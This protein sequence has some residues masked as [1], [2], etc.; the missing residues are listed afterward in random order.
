MNVE[1]LSVEEK[2][3][4]LQLLQLRDKRQRENMLMAYKPY[5]KQ[6][7]FHEAG[8]K[9][10]E[11][12]FM[13]GNQLGKTL[14]GS[15]ET[16]MHLT[17]RYPEWWTGLRFRRPI[18][19]ICGSETAELT[20]KGV[21][22][23]LLGPPEQREMW[24]TGA[25]PMDCVMRT[26]MLQGVPDAVA[27]ITVANEYGGESV[28]QFSS[29]AQGRAKWQA[30]TLDWVWFD[31]EPPEDIYS[32]GLTRTQAV[33]GKVIVTFTPLLG[34]SAVVKRFLRDKP[35]GTNVTRM[36]IDDAEHYTQEQR[37]AAVAKM[38]PHERDARARGIP[39]MGSGLVFPVAESTIQVEPFEIPQH[40]SRIN[41]WDF[42]WGHRAAWVALAHDRDTDTA[43]V[44]D[45]WSAKET[46]VM[47]QAGMVM[48]K[49][50]HVIPHAWPHDG[51]QHDK[52]SGEQLKEQYKKFGINM[53][54]ERAQF[55]PG[56]DGKPGGNSVEAGVAMM[57]TRFQSRQLR[58]F[59][60]LGDWFDEFRMYHRKDGIVVKMDDDLMSA[61]R[62]ALMDLRKAKTLQELEP[63]RRPFSPPQV[64][65]EKFQPFDEAV[66]Y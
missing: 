48:A 29:Y 41:A 64:L 50:S 12:L 55:A 25:I 60:H 2:L 35:P 61:T 34:M 52:G 7:E 63:V 14:A 11:R 58:V 24:G 10:D 33:G 51:L 19:A 31:E 15:F 57:L 46:P 28:I 40:W 38:L 18:R 20:R 47:Q 16:A 32:E 65:M 56:A 53:L 27:S 3:E 6:R 39:I 37:D 62:Y 9:F 5:S 26:S 36:T 21:Q 17:G 30:D 59:K 49:G 23:L 4:L 42:G 22:R 43:Y 54:P 45:C 1:S 66:A 8:A 13:A 44:Y